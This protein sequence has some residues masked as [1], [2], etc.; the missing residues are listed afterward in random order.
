M[1]IITL[2]GILLVFSS[3]ESLVCFFL[4]SNLLCRFDLCLC[5]DTWLL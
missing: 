2:K 3:I 4:Q 5:D 1:M